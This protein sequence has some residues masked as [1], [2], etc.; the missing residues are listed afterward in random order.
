M[1]SNNTPQEGWRD[2]FDYLLNV[3][4]PAHHGAPQSGEI[5]FPSVLHLDC[6]AALCHLPEVEGAALVDR[7]LPRKH[8]HNFEAPCA[9]PPCSLRATFTFL[10]KWI[11]KWR[12]CASFRFSE[13]L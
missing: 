10:R 7:K 13:S 3:L 8:W 9:L 1:Y 12:G 6:E 11:K 5:T 2:A 4:A